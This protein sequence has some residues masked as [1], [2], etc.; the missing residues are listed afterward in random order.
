MVMEKIVSITI[1]KVVTS[2]QVIANHFN[3]SHDEFIH[4]LRY[5]QHDCGVTFSKKIFSNRIAAILSDHICW[6]FSHIGIVYGRARC[7]YQDYIYRCVS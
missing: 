5:F 4:S 1:N 6:I 2:T 3:R 7:T